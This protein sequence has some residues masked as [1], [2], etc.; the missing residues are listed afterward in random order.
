MRK[1]HIKN[2]VCSRCTE[3]VESIF[4]DQGI[5]IKNIQLGEVIVDEITDLQI[6]S[7]ESELNQKGFEILKEKNSVLIQKVKNIQS[8]LLQITC[9]GCCGH[10][11][12]VSLSLS[13]PTECSA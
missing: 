13:L 4:K 8:K 1:I 9:C 10:I 3:A 5:C 6:L 11:E 2:M 12:Y 7:I